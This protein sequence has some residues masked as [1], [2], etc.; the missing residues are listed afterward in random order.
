CVRA[1]GWLLHY[2]DLW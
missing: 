2:F 1:V